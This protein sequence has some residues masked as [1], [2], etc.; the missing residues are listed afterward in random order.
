MPKAKSSAQIQ[1]ER[2][3][4]TRTRSARSRAAK[5]GHARRLD[6]VRRLREFTAQTIKKGTKRNKETRERLIDMIEFEDVR[7]TKFQETMQAKGF[8]QQQIR[9]FWMSPP[10]PGLLKGFL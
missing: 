9:N 6:N 2:A 8:S 5:L 1:R 7:W 10:K 3:A 4:R